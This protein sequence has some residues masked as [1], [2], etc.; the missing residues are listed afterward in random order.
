MKVIT[1]N[2]AVRDLIPDIIRAQGKECTVEQI[3]PQDFL[4][5]LKSKLTEEAAEYQANPSL[6][7]LADIQEVII[8]ILDLT[9]HSLDELEAVRAD[10]ARIRGGF[11][12]RLYLKTVIEGDDKMRAEYN[13]RQ[14]QLSDL[15]QIMDI[16]GQAFPPGIAE[17][18]ETFIQRLSIF[19]QGFYVL[20]DETGVCIG[21]IASEIW[22]HYTK[23]DFQLGH[24]IGAVHTPQGSQLYISSMGILP[25]HRGKG[26]GR[27]LVKGLLA[28]T[29]KLFP[30]LTGSILLVSAA[31]QQAREIYRQ[32][33]Y[34]E[35]DLIPGFFQPEGREPIDGVV[36]VKDLTC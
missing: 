3:P 4:Q 36:M 34:Q 12:K 17:S 13:L 30:N 28:E 29:S 21:Y 7:E 19:P 10:K 27:L 33:G 11:Q 35:H 26:L 5:L 9:G 14:A 2:K 20:V 1:Y 23:A 24:S 6:E 25:S 32:E 18:R 8:A 22:Q 16:E 31:W 15:E